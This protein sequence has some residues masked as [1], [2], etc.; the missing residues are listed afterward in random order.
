MRCATPSVP[1][2]VAVELRAHVVQLVDDRHQFVVE[3]PIQEPRQA[4][5]NEIENFTP[6]RDE[7]LHLV[8]RPAVSRR[9]RSTLKTHRRHAGLQAMSPS[10]ACPNDREQKPAQ[11]DVSE[12]GRSANDILA[13][14]VHRPREIKW[15]ARRAG[16]EPGRR[17]RNRDRSPAGQP[18]GEPR[19]RAGG[20]PVIGEGEGRAKHPKT[21]MAKVERALPLVYRSVRVGDLATLKSAF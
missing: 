18:Q 4:K 6:V 20:V 13:E 3:I 16:I 1:T 11:V 21:L 7:A 10:V 9:E 12:Y 5:G 14:R 8:G 15:L 19:R 2:K 17:F